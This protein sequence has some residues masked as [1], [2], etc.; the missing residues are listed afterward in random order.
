[1]VANVM[2]ITQDEPRPQAASRL[3]NFHTGFSELLPDHKNWLDQT[4]GPLL[5]RMEGT[6]VDLVGYASKLGN[7]ESNKALSARR[8]EEVK[9]HI[10]KL[11]KGINFQQETALGEEQSFGHEANNDGYFRAVEVYVYGFTPPP[12][13]PRLEKKKPKLSGVNFAIRIVSALSAGVGFAGADAVAFDI[14]EPSKG[15]WKRFWY[16]GGS[17]NLGVK[18]PGKLDKIIPPFSSGGS[19][20]S[21][22]FR[23]SRPVELEDFEGW[24]TLF[25]GPGIAL[26]PSLGGDVGLAFESDK[27]VKKR[28]FITPRVVVMGNDTGVG[29]TIYGAGKG[30]LELKES[31]R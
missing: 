12:L 27:L 1:M 3:C 6:W 19:G 17:M 23:T 25:S 16:T 29:I 11:K 26:G 13:K 10:A 15:K 28:A 31:I 5:W 22:P 9:K 8:V 7:T 24:A 21:V 2:P 4:I 18:L 20:S 14:G 30:W